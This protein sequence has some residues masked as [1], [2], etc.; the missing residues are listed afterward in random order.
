MTSTLSI[1]GEALRDTFRAWHAERDVIDSQL[2]ESL[3]ALSAYQSHLDEWQ[4]QLAR[5]RTELQ[6]AK[7]EF[8]SPS[9]RI[10]CDSPKG[11]NCERESLQAKAKELDHSAEQLQATRREIDRDREDIRSTRDAN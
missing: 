1:N 2:S 3:A 10:R 11:S 4:Q 8:D 6:T 9:S 7:E 5:E